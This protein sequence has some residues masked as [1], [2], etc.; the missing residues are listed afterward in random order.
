MSIAYQD[1]K[2][3][4]GT[5]YRDLV[6][7]VAPYVWKTKGIFL[8]VV[9]LVLTHT[10]LGRF[11][12]SLI[13]YT[14]DHF[15]LTKKAEFLLQAG[16]AYLLIEVFRYI[17]MIAETYL[18]QRL[19][20]QVI[21]QLR[22]DL[23][24]HVQRLPVSYFDRTPN[25]RIVTRLTNDF[26][27]LSELFTSGL[28][29]VFTDTISII[30]IVVAMTLISPK[31]TL[32]VLSISPLML[33]VSLWLSRNAR[34]TLRL[35][36]RQ[37]AR[38]N[39]YVSESL[40]GIKVIQLFNKESQT[41]QSFEKINESYRDFQ[42]E[43]LRYLAWLYPVLNGFNAITVAMALYFGGLI[44]LSDAVP[45]GSLVAFLM[46]TQDFLNPIRNILEKYQTFQSSL[47][48]AERIF[49]LLDEPAEDLTGQKISENRFMGNVEFKDVHFSYSPEGGEVLKGIDL[50]VLPGQSVA[51]VGP[52]GSGKSTIISL[53]QR[54]YQ[55]PKNQ[56]QITIDGYDISKLQAQELRRRVAVVQQ[57]PFLFKGTIASNISMFDPSISEETVR[58]AAWR[59]G[60]ED[61]CRSR[62]KGLDSLVEERGANLSVG[63][64]QLISFA[65]ILAFNPDILILDEATAFVDSQSEHLIQ[66][67]LK[68]VTRGRTSIIVAH[69][70][71]TILECERI[72]VLNQGRL[73]ESG[74]H[75]EL[76]KIPQGVYRNL[77]E[78]Q[79]KK[80]LNH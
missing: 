60:C 75:Q 16:A 20:L 58:Q 42:V 23:F 39:A 4:S 14:V 41:R 13:G 32:V 68:E 62:D 15:I 71:S 8:F 72:F 29:S 49:G 10:A 77:Y 3:Q 24:S 74:T 73:V 55:I 56:G 7:R 36:K 26:G 27:S 48:S 33:W 43:N 78:L 2:L 17:L 6:V 54:F 38:L 63:E 70:L 30:G 25:G 12:P 18:F 37:L 47:A 51:L 57:D 5:R 9:A 19:G 1:D 53:L 59:A 67:A 80:T 35:L 45:V 28:V 69:R 64:R 21:Y 50:Q 11:L 44:S 40:S 34:D 31:L 61:L 79:L 46:H 22:S 76:L 65:R 52:T 66:Q